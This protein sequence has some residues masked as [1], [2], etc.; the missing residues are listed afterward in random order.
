MQGFVPTELAEHH[1]GFPGG[2]SSVY[3]VGPEAWTMEGARSRIQLLKQRIVGIRQMESRS[4]A[5]QMVC[6]WWERKNE[7]QRIECQL[8]RL[9]PSLTQSLV[10]ESY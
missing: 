6:E 3:Q 5:K 10:L 4:M 8:G 9:S 2:R 1:K 7:R